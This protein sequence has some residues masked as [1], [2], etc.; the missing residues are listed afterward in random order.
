MSFACEVGTSSFG[1]TPNSQYTA[2][3]LKVLKKYGK[4]KPVD[5]V[6]RK[7]RKKFNKSA[8]GPSKK[9]QT[10]WASDFLTDKTVLVFPYLR[11]GGMTFLKLAGDVSDP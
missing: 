5:N 4:Y 7:V 2:A 6:L 3:L 1:G 8:S 9:L 10:P 11:S